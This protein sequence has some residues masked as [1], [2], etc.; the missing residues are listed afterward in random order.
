MSA[1]RMLH[2]VATILV[3]VALAT[4]GATAQTCVAPT[5][6]HVDSQYVA[7]T[8]CASS[9]QSVL[10]CDSIGE[11]GPAAVYRIDAKHLSG[12]IDTSANLSMLLVVKNTDCQTGNCL[13]LAPGSPILFTPDMEGPFSIVVAADP[14]VEANGACGSYTLMPHLTVIADLLKADGFDRD[15]GSR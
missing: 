4:S 3:F 9:E 15:F 12:S 10:L 5:L 6:L 13:A 2:P 8:T 7:G 14:R 11:G 1:S